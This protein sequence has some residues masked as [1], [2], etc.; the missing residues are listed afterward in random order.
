M[1]RRKLRVPCAYQGGKQRVASQI[2]DI[3]LA[4]NTSPTAVFY[5]LCCGSGAISIELVNRGIPPESIVM[6]DRSSWGTF[7]TSIGRGQFSMNIFRQLISDIP[8]DKRNVKP[9][10]VALAES[11]PVTNE[12]EVYPIL[13][14]SSFGGKQ[15]WFEDGVWQNAFF[16]SYWEPTETS[17]RRSPANPM[18]PSQEEL[19][20]RVASIVEHM[21]GVSARRGDVH[22]LLSE[23]VPDD[24]V[25]YVDPPYE[26][27]TGYGYGFSIRDFVG[28]FKAAHDVPLYVSEG[29]AMSDS[30][31][32]LH[33]G[34]A[35]GGISGSRARKHQEWLNRF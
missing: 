16:R 21:N 12:A 33:F 35:N 24:A 34:G 15:I 18:Q 8:S 26:N 3:M 19:Q 20:A 27:T 13:Q 11:L 29:I 31:L 23:S 25:V 22:D 32:Q 30:S 2:V 28:K 5:D 4:E 10:M 7:W 14:A 17:V 1:T 6:I 9:H